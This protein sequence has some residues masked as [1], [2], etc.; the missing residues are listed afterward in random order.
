VHQSFQGPGPVEAASRNS[1]SP[2]ADGVDLGPVRRVPRL[3]DT[4][5][6]T[7]LDA[8]VAGRFT[9]GE[10]LPSE[11]D[12]G[13]QFGVSR[14]V[15]REAIRALTTKGVIEVVA[16]RG[17]Q[18]LRPDGT[19]AAEALSLLLR[20]APGS[21]DAKAHEIR[22]MLEAHVVGIVAGFPADSDIS[23]IETHIEPTASGSPVDSHT[24]W[25]VDLA[26][27]RAIASSAGNEL[28]PVLLDAIAA[29]ELEMKERTSF[30][31][32][33][34]VLV[35]AH[36]EIVVCLRARDPVAARA[37]LERDLNYLSALW[38]RHAGLNEERAGSGSG[39]DWRNR[40]RLVPSL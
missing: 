11:R 21:G 4:I 33:L 29:A 3:A 40:R 25:A 10:V 6:Q 22:L 8:I 16:G 7:L 15:V 19:R 28:Y 38:D 23:D 26:F 14:T 37:A 1:P 24:A 36:R 9:V 27:H 35:Q 34:D 2:I 30:A 31:V 39:P 5:S 12:L 13:L 20:T 32:D 18:V 17:A